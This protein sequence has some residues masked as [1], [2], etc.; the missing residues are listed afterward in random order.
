MICKEEDDRAGN[1]ERG[2]GNRERLTTDKTDFT[3]EHGLR[4]IKV[5]V[6][7]GDSFNDKGYMLLVLN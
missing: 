4:T 3:D 6:L 1:G 5:N 2:T 7:D